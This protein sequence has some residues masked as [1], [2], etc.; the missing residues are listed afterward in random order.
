MPVTI[1]AF[2]IGHSNHALADFL[3]LLRQ[4]AVNAVA[5]VRSAPYSRFN[6]HFNREAFCRALADAGIGYFYRGSELGGRSD[7]PA[8]YRNGRISYDRVARTPRFRDGLHRLVEKDMAE[9]RIALMCAEKEPLHCHRTLLVAQ[10][11]DA[12]G[13]GIAHIHADGQLEKHAAAID[14]LLRLYGLNA[15]D[16]LFAQPR[17]A[18][19]EL[20]IRRQTERVGHVLNASGTER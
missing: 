10:A 12:E 1:D 18:L 11:L 7:D 4:H 6:A 2:T 19:V 9:H 3:A 5:D 16:D 14:R 17:T 20:A 8:C 13:V 15:E